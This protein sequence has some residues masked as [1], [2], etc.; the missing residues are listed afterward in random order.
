MRGKQTFVLPWITYEAIIYLLL[1]TTPE[2]TIFEWGGGASTLFWRNRGHQVTTIE[3]HHRWAEKL[4]IIP[5]SHRSQQYVE[6][7]DHEYDVVMIDGFRRVECFQHAK[8]YA[9]R[10]IVLDN[11]GWPEHKIV[12]T[13]FSKGWT[14]IVCGLLARRSP[15]GN[16]NR[17][18]KWM[19]TIFVRQEEHDAL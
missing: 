14:P 6:A 12:H 19:T 5:I 17:T 8:Q 3:S 13:R 16:G 10:M 15:F 9:R 4:G 1:N 11:S 7:L 18:A 2:D